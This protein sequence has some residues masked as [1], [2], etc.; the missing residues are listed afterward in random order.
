MY[1]QVSENIVWLSVG[2]WVHSLDQVFET[3]HYSSPHPPKKLATNLQLFIYSSKI[4]A[5]LISHVKHSCLYALTIQNTV[6]TPIEAKLMQLQYCTYFQICLP[7]FWCLSAFPP[8]LLSWSPTSIQKTLVGFWNYRLLTVLP[9][10]QEWLT[11][12]GFTSKWQNSANIHTESTKQDLMWHSTY[13]HDFI[14]CPYVGNSQSL[15]FPLNQT[16]EQSNV[17][18]KGTNFCYIATL[19]IHIALLLQI[20]VHQ[21]SFVS[22]C[23]SKCLLH[24][25][26]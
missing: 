16:W 20:T 24:G 3:V 19:L 2:W 8:S 22:N 4:R 18:T 5:G 21:S 25:E 6:I 1:D 14:S 15:W 13:N 11:P 17:Q 9:T 23:I 12:W 7:S 10:Y 26:C